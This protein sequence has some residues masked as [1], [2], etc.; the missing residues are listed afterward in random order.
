MNTVRNEIRSLHPEYFAFVMASGIVSIGMAN[1]GQH[2]ISSILLWVAGIAYVVL[3]ILTAMR[4]AA[5]APM[6]GADFT[7]PARG[8]SFFTFVAA[9]DV[10][11]TRLVAAGHRSIALVLLAV[12]VV[13]WLILGYVVPWT[14]LLGQARRP[15]LHAA[16]GTWF[17]WVVGSQSVAILAASLAASGSSGRSG[18]ALLAV[19]CWVLGVCAYV[20]VAV[21]VAARGL[22][23]ELRPSDLTSP[24][25]ISMGA[26]AITVVAGSKI[27][28]LHDEAISAATRGLISGMSVVMWI[29]ATW[30]VPALIAA[31]VWRHIVHRVSLGYQPMLWSVVFPLGMYGVA[32]DSLSEVHDLPII[33]WIGSHECWIALL[34]WA[35][36]FAAMVWHLLSIARQPT[37]AE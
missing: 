3:V 19:S 2:V 26:A 21:L 1:H 11:G 31:G 12:A 14:A 8:F 22:L 10:L 18:L 6:V 20:V 4:F 9:S 23:Y 34:A 15:V 13:V 36:V 30:L 28:L 33:G 37:P 29:V 24:Y 27:V 25:W 32:S 35:L 16:N 5:Y 7:D 17:L